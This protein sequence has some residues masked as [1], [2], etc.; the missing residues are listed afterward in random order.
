LYK[1]YFIRCVTW[2]HLVKMPIWGGDRFY[3]YNIVELFFCLWKTYR[4]TKIRNPYR[5]QLFKY[6]PL[7]CTRS[8]FISILII[9]DILFNFYQNDWLWFICITHNMFHKTRELLDFKYLF[10][11]YRYKKKRVSGY[12]SAAH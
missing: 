12:R 5:Y 3:I 6:L 4:Q 9:A 10:G 2:K 1:L 8:I 7:Y 11:Y